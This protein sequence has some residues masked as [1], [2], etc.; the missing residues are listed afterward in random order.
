MII[1][2][3]HD[4]CRHIFVLEE[5]AALQLIQ[6][7]TNLEV[8]M[9][10]MSDIVMNKLKLHVWLIL[11]LLVV[12]FKPD[13]HCNFWK[14]VEM[15]VVICIAHLRAN[16]DIMIL[17]YSF[18]TI[19]FK[20]RLFY[21]LFYIFTLPVMLNIVFLKIMLFNLSFANFRNWLCS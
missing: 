2:I 11:K 12:V 6:L 3:H 21:F 7:V 10:E 14:R 18:N 20:I 1:R 16:S 8:R 19:L 15:H 5:L 4:I 17:H 13:I 9:I